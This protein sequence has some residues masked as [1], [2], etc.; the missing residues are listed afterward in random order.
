VSGQNDYFVKLIGIRPG[1]PKRYRAAPSERIRPNEAVVGAG[2]S[3][4]WTWSHVLDNLH[5]RFEDGPLDWSA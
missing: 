5:K 4:A 3:E 2:F 1:W